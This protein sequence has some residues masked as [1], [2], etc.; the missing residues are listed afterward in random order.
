MTRQSLWGI[1]WKTF[2]EGKFF[3][4][5]NFYHLLLS[6]EYKTTETAELEES[7]DFSKKKQD[8]SNQ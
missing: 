3:R 1:Q 4:K 7:E 8:K 2:C 6:T 5:E